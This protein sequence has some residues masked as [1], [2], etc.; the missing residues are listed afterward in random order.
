MPN[1]W[2]HLL[3]GE[4][5]AIQSGMNF[6][7]HQKEFQ[8][9]TQGPDSFFY[10]HFWPWK[11]TDQSVLQIGNQIHKKHCGEFLLN[12]IDYLK[13]KPNPLLK[14]YVF[15]FMSHH[16]LDRNAHPYIVYR[17]GEE[18]NKHQKLEIYIDTLMM[19]K[20]KDI[21]TWKVPV[22]KK[23]DLGHN[24]PQSI[25]AMLTNL[26]QQVHGVNRGT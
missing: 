24:L 13:E 7:S 8:L 18:G 16:V 5:I 11:K 1:V 12:M 14:A 4:R 22:Y 2:T 25:L 17:S 6:S 23:L 9:G 20:Y 21:D 19:K 15:G 3:F 26:M 10:Y